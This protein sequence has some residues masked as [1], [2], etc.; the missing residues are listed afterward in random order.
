MKV[1]KGDEEKIW[2]VLENTY[3]GLIKVFVCALLLLLLI[4]FLATNMELTIYQELF[5]E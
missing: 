5:Q 3:D 4:Y 2:N 1:E